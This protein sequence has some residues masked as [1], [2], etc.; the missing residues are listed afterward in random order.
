MAATDLEAAMLG[1]LHRIRCLLESLVA[2]TYETKVV[3]VPIPVKVS[4]AKALDLA[5]RMYADWEVE[6]A[7][8]EVGIAPTDEL[9]NGRCAVVWFRRLKWG[10]YP[11][12]LTATHIPAAAPA[13]REPVERAELSEDESPVPENLSVELLTVADACKRFAMARHQVQKAMNSGELPCL[14]VPP[15]IHNARNPNPL[16]R[17][18]EYRLRVD[19]VQRWFDEVYSK[20]PPPKPRGRK[21]RR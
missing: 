9:P 13:A 8:V 21:A 17:E 15:T 5:R 4:R 16:G 7:E 10:G 3:A 11:H 14:K 18:Y 1:E 6:H 20:L 2:P 12:D 19:D